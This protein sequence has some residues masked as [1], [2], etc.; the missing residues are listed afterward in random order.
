MPLLLPTLTTTA[1]DA[2]FAVCLRAG[3]HQ[4]PTPVSCSAALGMFALG[5]LQVD[6]MQI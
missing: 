2:I 6:V 5:V 4:P 1:G 3:L